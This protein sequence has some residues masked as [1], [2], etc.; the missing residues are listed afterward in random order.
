MVQSKLK[1]GGLPAVPTAVPRQPQEEEEE[2]DDPEILCSDCE[3]MVPGLLRDRH[4]DDRPLCVY[5]RARRDPGWK[6]TK[7][8]PNP[9]DSL[10]PQHGEKE[11]Q[12]WARKERIRLAFIKEKCKEQRRLDV[13]MEV[14]SDDS[15]DD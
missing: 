4:E 12:F 2:K 8:R 7:F 1:A 3:E 10:R 5:E 15:S 6:S 14:L 9:A 13:R 11:T